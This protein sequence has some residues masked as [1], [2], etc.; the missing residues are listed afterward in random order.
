MKKI[1]F[2]FIAAFFTLIFIST[3]AQYVFAQPLTNFTI[4]YDGAEHLYSEAPI[5]LVINGKPAENL[6]VPP[7]SFD[8]NTLVPA[9]ELFEILGAQV[10][11]HEQTKK[12]SVTYSD[13]EILLSL[14]SNVAKINGAEK[15]M[16]ISPRIINDKTMIPLRFVADNLGFLVFW[17]Q[18]TRTIFV[19]D[20]G[21]GVSTQTA[22]NPE[23]AGGASPQTAQGG[24]HPADGLPEAVQESVAGSALV[25]EKI[26]AESVSQPS[27]IGK[28]PT[29]EEILEMMASAGTHNTDNSDVDL[30]ININSNTF[31]SDSE[32][33]I[34]VRDKSTAEIT[35]E[36]HPETWITDILEP[37][38]GNNNFKITAKTAISRV[39]K[40]ILE[41][42]RMYLDIYGAILEVGQPSF[43][44]ADNPNVASIR[45]AQNQ[46]TPEKIV[47]V[48]F[49][50]K[51]GAEYFVALSADRTE[52]TVGFSRNTITDFSVKT[53]N[54]KDILTVIAASTP[55]LSVMPSNEKEIVIEIPYADIEK[56]GEF[57][58]Y[59]GE[60][61]SSVKSE[62]FDQN[63]A[64]ITLYLKQNVGYTLTTQDNSAMVTLFTPTQKNIEYDFANSQIVLK[65]N[66]FWSILNFNVNDFIHT[67]N[68]SE[69][70]Y[71]ITIPA[72]LSGHFG[73]GEYIVRD[74]FINSVSVKTENGQTSIIIDEVRIL[75][76][77]VYEEGDYIYIKPVLPKQKYDKI[78]VIDPG[79]GGD[80]PGTMGSGMI[81]RD[82][83]LDIALKLH[84]L[85]ENDGRVKVYS[86]R[87]TDIN[88]SFE[89]RAQFGTE[90]GDL[91]ISIHNNYAEY[92]PGVTNPSVSG[93]ET[94]YYNYPSYPENAQLSK[95][96]AEI[97]QENMVSV[98]NSY[99]REVKTNNFMVLILSRV[100]AVLCEVGF[101]SNPEEAQKL[102]SD[103]YR[104]QAAQGFFDGIISIFE[105]MPPGR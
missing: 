62:Q 66:A 46:I 19:D 10:L 104:L 56:T 55:N 18:N 40:N 15:Q 71:I 84:E 52:I 41:D 27:G 47:R 38:N 91:F 88:P 90:N 14:G 35:A 101:F 44:F 50:L 32:T 34:P 42:N 76:Y 103:S 61:I 8:G 12:I 1:S 97:L 99:D 3:G 83:N 36:N 25:P 82:I 49:D 54:G 6:S 51:D 98:L 79:H 4:F 96:A 63:T 57:A 85:L 53:E 67:D 73:Q 77:N 100:P 17:E 39:E 7:L 75:A 87:L 95:K 81:E 65:K 29:E 21:L 70:K 93:T 22:Q 26:S 31:V 20:I 74:S 86:T 43:Y 5:S 48:V 37:Q 58:E 78:V 94:Y 30:N 105:Q 28:L 80:A 89:E 45:A 59:A 24:E 69:F 68:Y 9:R 2:A 60:F 72:D 11:W 92:K 23:H 64:R 16:V 33:A 102:A 13:T